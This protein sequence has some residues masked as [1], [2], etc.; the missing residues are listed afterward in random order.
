M[1]SI[2]EAHSAAATAIYTRR[3]EDDAFR[4]REEI[5]INVLCVFYYNMARMSTHHPPFILPC[6]CDGG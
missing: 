3:S 5:I 4:G 2:R 1:A 6:C